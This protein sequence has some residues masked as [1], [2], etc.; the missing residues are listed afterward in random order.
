M[1]IF[2]F[3][4]FDVETTGLDVEREEI[5]EIAAVRFTNGRQCDVFETLVHPGR[6]IPAQATRIHGITDE[7]VEE[8]PVIPEIMGAFS[9]FCGDMIMVAHNAPFDVQFLAWAVERYKTRAPGGVVLD[10]C[11]IARQACPN[12][13]GYSLK[14]LISHFQIVHSRLH[15]AA[16]DAAY[17]GDLFVKLADVVF[18]PQ[19]EPSVAKLIALSGGELRLPQMDAA[20]EQLRLFR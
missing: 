7:M 3:V 4:A 10:S 11:A 5:V 1:P 14:S 19:G 2:D 6:P 17:C 16:A 12:L 13:F 9:D 18:G 20:A 15:R 8:S